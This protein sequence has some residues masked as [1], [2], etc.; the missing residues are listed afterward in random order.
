M[1]DTRKLTGI[2]AFLGK[3]F[4]DLFADLTIRNLDIVLGLARVGHEGE[5]AVIG[6]IELLA[7]SIHGPGISWCR[8]WCPLTS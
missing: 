3:K 4:M 2:L 7:T 5:K 8:G 6:N 1:Q